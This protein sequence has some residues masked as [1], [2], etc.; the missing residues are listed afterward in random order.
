MMKFYVKIHNNFIAVCDEDL[1]NK[2]FEDGNTRLEVSARFYKDKLLDYKEVKN[3]LA[4][5]INLN[6]VGNKCVKLALDNKII[7]KEN[8]LYIKGI[9]HAQIYTI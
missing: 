9:P 3:L 8:I 7:K 5:G 2:T 1:I 6:L 4:N